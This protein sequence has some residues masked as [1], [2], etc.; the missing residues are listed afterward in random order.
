MSNN[1]RGSNGHESIQ[2]RR[3]DPTASRGSN[4]HETVQ[5]PRQDP[6]ALRSLTVLRRPMTTTRDPTTQTRGASNQRH[7]E[8]ERSWKGS[9]KNNGLEAWMEIPQQVLVGVWWG[10]KREQVRTY[11]YCDYKSENEPSHDKGTA[12]TAENHRR[13]VQ[14]SYKVHAHVP[15]T[16]NLSVL[17]Q[18]Q[19]PKLSRSQ[20]W[21]SS[22]GGH[23][24]SQYS[25]MT[26]NSIFRYKILWRLPFY[27]CKT[28]P[29]A[30]YN[31]HVNY[32][33]TCVIFRKVKCRFTTTL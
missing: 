20:E 17:I 3:Q 12:H 27:T 26:P 16:L 23:A 33:E 28:H 31:Y 14:K 21:F 13:Y 32:W 4:G 10:E 2:R 1:S 25:N 19:A 30:S 6:T 18:V 15:F 29:P 24:N 9:P 5:R 8:G 11:K 22:I 7:C